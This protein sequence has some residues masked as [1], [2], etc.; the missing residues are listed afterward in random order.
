[1]RDFHSAARWVHAL[2][3]GRNTER[4]EYSLVLDE[5]RGT[6]STKHALLAAL[7]RDANVAVHL[8]AGIFLMDEANTPGV[9]D[10]LRVHGLPSVPEAHCVLAFDGTISDLTFPETNGRCALAFVVERDLIPEEIGSAKRAWH[11]AFVAQWA[12]S[13]GLDQSAVWAAREACIAALGEL[14]RIDS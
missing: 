3:Y 6:C 11:Q 9:G 8:R 10:A 1:M 7:A 2:P 13:L 5:R 14:A 12:R 4:S